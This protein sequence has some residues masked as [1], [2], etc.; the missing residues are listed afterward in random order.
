M[1]PFKVVFVTGFPDYGSKSF[2]FQPIDFLVKGAHSIARLQE[3]IDKC[4]EQIEL[5]TYYKNIS[6]RTIAFNVGHGLVLLKVSEIIYAKPENNAYELYTT[7][8]ERLILVNL[9][10]TKLDIL[11][12]LLGDDVFLRVQKSYLINLEHI[13]SYS[14]KEGTTVVMSNGDKIPIG[15]DVGYKNALDDYFN[16]LKIN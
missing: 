9:P 14:T 15:N 7:R 6:D 10:G 11:A 3:A 4:R 5:E 2:D 16:S 13:I 1:I 8:K 12:K